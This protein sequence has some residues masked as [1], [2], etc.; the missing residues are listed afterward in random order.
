MRCAPTCACAVAALVQL[1]YSRITLSVTEGLSSVDHQLWALQLLMARLRPCR[2]Q[3]AI[4][5]AVFICHH[6]FI[7]RSMQKNDRYVS[8]VRPCRRST[9]CCL[10]LTAHKPA[11]LAVTVPR[12]QLLI[13]RTAS[14]SSC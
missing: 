2:P 4:Y 6:Y 13:V 14:E 8:A 7:K 12:W 9:Q 1:V 3:W 11:A 10:A 5:T